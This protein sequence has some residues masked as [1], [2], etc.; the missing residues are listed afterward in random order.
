MRSDVDHG[1]TPNPELFLLS[2]TGCMD[3]WHDIFHTSPPKFLSLS[4]M[5]KAIRYEQQRALLGGPSKQT[6]RRIKALA[7][8]GQNARPTVTSLKTG[9]HLIREWNGRTYQV[10]VVEGGFMMD[11]QPYRSLTAIAKRITGAQWSGPRFFGLST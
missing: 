9:N 8:E 1:S 11:G 10:E 4:F 5:Q 2:R 6:V 3:A 7:K